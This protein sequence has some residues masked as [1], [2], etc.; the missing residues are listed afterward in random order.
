MLGGEPARQH[1]MSQPG[2]CDPEGSLHFYVGPAAPFRRDRLF[3]FHRQDAKD[4]KKT[5]AFVGWR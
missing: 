2:R 5:A 1:P 3:F 4:A